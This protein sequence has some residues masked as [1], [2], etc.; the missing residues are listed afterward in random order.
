[1]T[2]GNGPLIVGV[3]GSPGALA[4][5][6]WSIRQA[7][8]FRTD[9]VAVH[10]WQPSEALRAPYAPVADSP[11][12]A[13]DR[14]QAD[15]LLGTTVSRVVAAEPGA[16]LRAFLTEGPAV[17]VLIDRVDEALLL[18]LGHRLRDDPALPARGAVARECVRRAPCPVVTVPEPAPGPPPRQDEFDVLGRTP[19]LGGPR[20]RVPAL[21]VPG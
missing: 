8:L 12:A 9:V 21:H 5:L 20:P 19:S 3:D 7:R 10:A 18:V 15:R 11:T 14:E 4:A 13:D 17:P 1:M 6:R 16:R 2:R